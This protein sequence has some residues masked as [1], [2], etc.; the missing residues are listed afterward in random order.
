[1]LGI[2]RQPAP[3]VSAHLRIC[4]LPGSVDAG[5]IGVLGEESLAHVAAHKPIASKHNNLFRLEHPIQSFPGC[6]NAQR[7]SSCTAHETAEQ[8]AS[9]IIRKGSSGVGEGQHHA[10]RRGC[11]DN[12]LIRARKVQ[13]GSFHTMDSVD[14]ASVRDERI[15]KQKRQGPLPTTHT[16]PRLTTNNLDVVTL[17]LKT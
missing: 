3:S 10:A 8:S 5:D 17:K 2:M 15:M 4:G 1:M 16:F 11:F 6:W 9:G 12:P 7:R 14:N 13:N